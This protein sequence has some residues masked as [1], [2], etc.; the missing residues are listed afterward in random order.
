[1]KD[2]I[3]VIDADYR[4]IDEQPIISRR[5]RTT[6]YLSV[7]VVGWIA[8]IATILYLM[9]GNRFLYVLAG[10]IIGIFATLPGILIARK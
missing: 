10:A 6:I 9:Y 2:I 1:M 5:S 8:L 7:V 4:E 3:P